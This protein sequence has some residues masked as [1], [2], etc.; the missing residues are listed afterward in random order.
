MAIKEYPSGGAIPSVSGQRGKFLTT[1]GSN[2][3]WG[4]GSG[5]VSIATGTLSGASITI[6]NIPNTYNNLYLE[7]TNYIPSATARVEMRFN[8]DTGGNYYT[9]SSWASAT[10]QTPTATGMIIHRDMASNSPASATFITEIPSYKNTSS[11]K[12]IRVYGVSPNTTTSTNID[13]VPYFGVWSPSTKAAINSIT[14]FP[15]GANFSSGTYVL[16]GVQ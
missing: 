7:L 13:V 9:A 2:L 4:V 8:G 11:S 3:S 1:N 14:I 12:I 15:N 16:Y 10:G 6:S 5:M